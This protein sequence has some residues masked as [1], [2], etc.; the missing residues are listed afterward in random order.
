VPE[1]LIKRSL[2]RAELVA[3]GRTIAIEYAE[4]IFSFFG[5]KPAAQIVAD[6]QRQVFER[7]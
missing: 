3:R 2:P 5:W 7:R 1:I 6:V 4:E